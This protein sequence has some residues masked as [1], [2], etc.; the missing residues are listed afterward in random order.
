MEGKVSVSINRNNPVLIQN[1][2]QTI[3]TAS[4]QLPM[5]H[6]AMKAT[7][8]VQMATSRSTVVISS[9]SLRRDA[10]EVLLSEAG[11]E[12][13]GK[14]ET[15]RDAVTL[16]DG[17]APPALILIDVLDWKEQDL[18]T[19]ARLRPPG[20]KTNIVVLTER[21]AAN[22]LMQLWRAGVGGLL[23]PDIQKAVL[24]RYL[25]LVLI[26][27]RVLHP[28]VLADTRYGDYVSPLSETGRAARLS[29]REHEV[30]RLVARGLSNKQMARELE[31]ADGTVKIHVR[32]MCR[33]VGARNRTQL[34]AWAVSRGVG[35]R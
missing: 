21:L 16:V 4:A 12:I 1:K 3:D 14:V 29:A 20:S 6:L 33:K 30:L 35:G 19:V 15:L 11:F 34:A 22:R 10:L 28:G 24:M 31:I 17:A 27:E 18:E 25:E 7:S 23:T 5:L 32:N 13:I 9:F 8:C 2:A 26:G